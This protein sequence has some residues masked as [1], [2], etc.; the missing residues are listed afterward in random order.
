MAAKKKITYISAD[1]DDSGNIMVRWS[2]EDTGSRQMAWE[3]KSAVFKETEKDL[4][5]AK[6][7]E[8]YKQ[9]FEQ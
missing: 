2:I 9:K 7:I 4:A 6:V 5:L 3:D 8:L 1:V